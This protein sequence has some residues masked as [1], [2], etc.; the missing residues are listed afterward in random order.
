MTLPPVIPPPPAGGY[1]TAAAAGAVSY[2]I[3]DIGLQLLP[4]HYSSIRDAESNLAV[5]PYGWIM[6]LNFLGRAATTACT[7]MAIRRTGADTS[8]RRTG[9][10]LMGIGGASSAV[11]AFFPTDVIVD[12]SGFIATTVAGS[13]HLGVAGT[14]FAA[15]LAALVLLTGWIRGVRADDEGRKGSG[16][17]GPRTMPHWVHPCALGATAV[18]CAGMLVLGASIRFAPQF[19]GLTERICLAGILG[20]VFV[21]G[22]GTSRRR[23]SRIAGAGR[24]YSAFHHFRIRPQRRV[25]HRLGPRCSIRNQ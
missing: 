9:I 16:E 2:V 17:P 12:A 22:A 7:I 8:L 1:G 3:V 25:D 20:W 19:A 24:V 4:P 11:L 15:A 10:L 23:V 14:G 13:I 6:N 18:A 21:V 5:G